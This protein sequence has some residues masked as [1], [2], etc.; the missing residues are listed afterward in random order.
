MS[1]HVLVE[2]LSAYILNELPYCC[3]A[4]IRVRPFSS[5]VE[6]CLQT[7][8]VILAQWWNGHLRLDS[9]SKA[10]TNHIREPAHRSQAGCVRQE[11][12]KRDWRCLWIRMVELIGFQILVYW[13]IELKL[14]LLPQL[15]EPDG[16]DSLRNR[17]DTKYRLECDRQLLLHMGESKPLCIDHLI[18]V[19]DA[20]AQP[21]KGRVIHCS[22][23]HLIRMCQHEVN[24]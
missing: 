20:N 14:L 2:W 4:V 12:T 6:F 9:E 10:R 7:L 18:L 5:W 1:K 16:C 11:M 15:H 24:N 23:Y 3:K 21:S 17:C 22:D 13:S 8:N 19:N